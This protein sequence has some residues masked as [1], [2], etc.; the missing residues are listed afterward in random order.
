MQVRLRSRDVT[1]DKNDEMKLTGI[2]EALANPMVRH[3]MELLALESRPGTEL[4]RHFDLIPN[5]LKRLGENLRDLGLITKR[6]YDDY[7]FED[8]G[9][10]PIQDWL[11]RIRSL[12]K[13]PRA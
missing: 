2:L 9:L 7:V 11:D 12:K 3:F 4:C 13:P 6:S 1:A 5:D 8:G 10:A